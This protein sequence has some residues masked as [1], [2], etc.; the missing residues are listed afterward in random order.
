MNDFIYSKD[1]INAM[2]DEY[3]EKGMQKAKMVGV[4]H[5]LEKLKPVIEEIYEKNIFYLSYFATYA[6]H[7]GWTSEKLSPMLQ[8]TDGIIQK[9]QEIYA[10][11]HCGLGEKFEET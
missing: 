6:P 10:L 3:I 7:C 4:R 11:I 9:F 5:D 1:E 8:I 2:I